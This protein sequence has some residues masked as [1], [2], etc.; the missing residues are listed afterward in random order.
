MRF[1]EIMAAL[2]ILAPSTVCILKLKTSSCGSKLACIGCIIHA[3]FSFSL[4]MYKAIYPNGEL[5]RTLYA[6][7]I[8]GIHVW[9]ILTGFSW[10]YMHKMYKAVQL[11]YHFA[12]ILYIIDNVQD[13]CTQPIM[14]KNIGVGVVLSSLPFIIIKPDLW[15]ISHAFWGVGFW[16][17]H[18]KIFGDA[19]SSVMHIL[20]VVPQYCLATRKI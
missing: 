4:H 8:I 5:K 19:S 20:L 17:H 10:Q 7:D 6:M 18:T 15:I 9:A 2:T 1:S 12:C 16:V 13:I 3:P 11:L 14:E